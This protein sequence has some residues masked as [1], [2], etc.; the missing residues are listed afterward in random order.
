MAE[1]GDARGLGQRLMESAPVV[2]VYESRL[3]RRN[4]LVEALMGI[5]FADELDCITRAARLDAASRV[6]DLACGPGIYARPFARRLVGGRVVGLD[7]S[8]PMLAYAQGRR[9]AEGLTNL[10]LVRGSALALP[11]TAARFDAVNCCGALHLFADVPGALAEVHRVLAAG[12][13]LTMAVVRAGPRPRD[14]RAARLRR[15]LLGVHSFARDDLQRLVAEAGFGEFAAL[16]E[17][18]LWM[19]AAA[20]KRQP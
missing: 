20:T 16:H 9:R 17:H 14:R 6:L 4:P 11:F 19:I 8:R 1:Y 2:A 13:R 10:D 7:L 15:R 5:S 3:W 18:G 12:G